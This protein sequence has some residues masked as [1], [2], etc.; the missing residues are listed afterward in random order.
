MHNSSL[1]ASRLGLFA[2]LAATIACAYWGATLIAAFLL[3]VLLLG[4]G[5]SAWSRNV[6]AKASVSIADGQTACHA[7][8]TLPLTLTVHS[9][10]L[11]PLI[12]LDVTVPFGERLLVKREGD[13]QPQLE[14]EPYQKPQYGFRER[15]AWLLWQQEITCEESLETLHRGV[16]PIDP[17]ERRWREETGRALT[18]VSKA[19]DSVTRIF[20]GLPLA[21]K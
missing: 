6:L 4:L 17:F 20:C 12:W 8:D 19:S 3:L 9:R 14:A 15:F 5:A 18:A 1:F 13:E 11:F 10:S 2:L 16:V 7:G 21:L